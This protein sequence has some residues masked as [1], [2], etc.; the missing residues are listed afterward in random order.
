MNLI[1]FFSVSIPY[2]S[3]SVT[4]HS[5]P[6]SIPIPFGMSIFIYT[7]HIYMYE[8]IVVNIE[9]Q[10]EK[11]SSK[12]EWC[13]ERNRSDSTVKKNVFVCLMIVMSIMFKSLMKD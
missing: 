3:V 9:F 7:Y 13:W 6:I 5:I 8:C 4:S 11:L 10:T 2:H 1:L 12:N